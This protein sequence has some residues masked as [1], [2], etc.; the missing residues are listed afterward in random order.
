[1]TPPKPDT[2]PDP[3]VGIA[4]VLR[5]AR[6]V[7][8]GL[9]NFAP[10]ADKENRNNQDQPKREQSKYCFHANRLAASANFCKLQRSDG[11]A[12]GLWSGTRV[13]FDLLFAHRAALAGEEK[14]QHNHANNRQKVN[15][16]LHR[17]L[18]LVNSDET[19]GTRKKKKHSLNSKHLE[20]TFSHFAIW[21]NPRVSLIGGFLLTSRNCNKLLLPVFS[22]LAGGLAGLA[23]AAE[24]GASYHCFF[25]DTNLGYI[26]E[27]GQG[28]IELW[29]GIVPHV[30]RTKE[31]SVSE[32]AELMRAVAVTTIT[33]NRPAPE[34]LPMDVTETFRLHNPD[35]PELTVT[36]TWAKSDGT[37]FP[38]HFHPTDFA[39]EPFV[40]G[41]WFLPCTKGMTPTNGDAK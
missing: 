38:D 18:S 33:S 35:N 26:V 20:P 15:K 14:H 28:R 10:A 7:V 40:P 22:V 6:S 8:I 1:M 11:L 2:Q 17:A 39:P 19:N 24:H 5:A 4:G 29:G 31:I 36:T 30:L 37:P 9:V 27:P 32:G 34:F 21:N 16:A 13:L 25:K 23:N 12:V 3:S 41:T